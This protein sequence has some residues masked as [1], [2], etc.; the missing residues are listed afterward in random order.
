MVAQPHPPRV[1][2]LQGLVVIDVE[3]LEGEVMPL[4]CC[5]SHF[6]SHNQ[7][8]GHRT[9]SSHSRAEEYPSENHKQ[10]KMVHAYITADAVH[11]STRNMYNLKSGVSPRCARSIPGAYVSLLAPGKIDYTPCHPRKTTTYI[12]HVVSITTHTHD[13]RKSI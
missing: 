13:R 11:A 4:C 8:R 9:G 3:R 12:F 1:R 7:A 2:A 5:C 6:N 10:P